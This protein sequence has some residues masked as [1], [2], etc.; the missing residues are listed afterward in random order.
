MSSGTTSQAIDETGGTLDTVWLHKSF[1]ENVIKQT[2]VTTMGVWTAFNRVIQYKNSFSLSEDDHK[3]GPEF[4][5]KL[6]L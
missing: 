2:K 1:T 3:L 6:P 5:N 4:N